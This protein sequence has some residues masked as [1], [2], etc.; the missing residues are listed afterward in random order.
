[1]LDNELDRRMSNMPYTSLVCTHVRTKYGVIVEILN[2]AAKHRTKGKI[3]SNLLE[4]AVI[5]GEIDIDIKTGEVKLNKNIISKIRYDN[6]TETERLKQL[7]SELEEEVKS[8][9]EEIELQKIKVDFNERYIQ[10][11][12]EVIV[13][14]DAIDSKRKIQVV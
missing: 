6:P 9:K 8:L 13:K 2:E 3:L 7:N 14:K 5:N 11:L 4:L 1:V 12:S 10:V